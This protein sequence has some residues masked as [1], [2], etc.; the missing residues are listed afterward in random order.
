MMKSKEGCKIMYKELIDGL[1]GKISD[2]EIENIKNND[3]H[4][5]VFSEPYLEYMLNGKK[6]IESRFSKKK[7]LPYKNVKEGDYVFVKKSGGDVVAYFKVGKVL[8]FDFNVDDINEIRREY[9]HPLC[10]GNEFF[11]AKKDSQYASL[12]FIDK[13]IKIKPYHINKRGMNTW[14]K[15]KKDN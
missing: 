13:L 7:I 2:L 10:V 4:L 6:T 8:F 14:I 9:E 1:T 15:I 5:G 11:D 3:I 12:I